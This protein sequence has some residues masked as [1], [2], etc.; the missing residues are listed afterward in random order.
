[1]FISLKTQNGVAPNY[2]LSLCVPVTS[3]PTRAA[4]CSVAC[5]DLVVPHTRLCLGNRAFCVTAPM[6]WNSLLSDV[7]TTS[8][9]STFKKR[10]DSVK[11]DSRVSAVVFCSLTLIDLIRVA[12]SVRC[13][14]SDF[15]NMLQ[16]LINCRF[17]IIL[18]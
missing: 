9:L 6:A 8:T 18:S 11:K 13:P 12:Y 17:I 2:I 5:G 4:L 3:V 7:Q 1:M 10:Q 14:C 16:R 15:T